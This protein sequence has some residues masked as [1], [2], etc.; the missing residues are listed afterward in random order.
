M[1]TSKKLSSDAKAFVPSSQLKASA[2][3]WTP[4]SA[5]TSS[6]ATTGNGTDSAATAPAV[7][8]SSNNVPGKNTTNNPNSNSSEV[9][10]DPPSVAPSVTNV[11]GKNASSAIRKAPTDEQKAIIEG[12][13]KVPTGTGEPMPGQRP[14][15]HNH[16]LRRHPQHPHQQHNDKGVH[17]TQH[18]KHD[19]DSWARGKKPMQPKN[20]NDDGWQRGKLVPLDLIKPGEGDLDANKNVKRILAEHILSLR[21]SFLDPPATWDKRD[22]QEGSGG[23]GCGA[24]IACRWISDSRIE[25]IRAITNQQRLGG[26]VSSHRKVKKENDTAPPLEE[27]KPL[28]INEDTRWKATVFKKEKD[29]EDTDD[30]VLKKALLILNKLSITKF[31]KLSDAFLETGIGRNENCL[32][33]AIGL[34]VKK[35]QDEPH[36]SAMYASL[37]LKLART[38]MDF[39]ESG[40][41]KKFK[42]MLLAECQK[43]FETDTNTKIEKATEGVED[44]EER[45]LKADLVKKHYLGH[46]RFIGE[47][48]KGDL[49]TIKIMLMVL[50]Q[51]LEGNMNDGGMDEDK[52]ECF[53]KLMTVIGLILEQQSAALRNIGK[54]DASEKL[55]ECWEKVEALAG[56]K[57]N[58]AT[59]SN[60][61]KF[62]L[63]DLL[64]MKENGWASRRKEESAKT[65]EEIHKD[66]AKEVRRMSSS[67]SRSAS[68]N[69][70]RA[71]SVKPAVDSDGFVEVLGSGRGFNRPKSVGNLRTELQDNQFENKT[72]PSSGSKHRHVSSDQET[73]DE[74]KR[75]VSK[76]ST[77]VPESRKVSEYLE[78]SMCANKAVRC[79]KE[80]FVSGDA[81]ETVLTI[82]ELIGAGTDG[83]IKRAAKVIESTVLMV[84]EMKAEEV[85]KYQE[86]ITRCYNEKKIE[87]ASF[88]EAL[89]YPFESLQDIAIDAPLANI[90]LA[91]IVASF[92]K[93]GAISFDYLWKASPDSFRTEGGAAKFGVN[94]LKSI[95]GDALKAKSNLDVIEQLMTDDDKAQY[96]SAIEM[97]SS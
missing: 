36:F 32:A 96:A 40:K 53:A 37:C 2:A 69:S 29:N 47:L 49:I 51:L 58:D 76:T 8:S 1:T 10:T 43:E 28:E 17:K 54:T 94:V 38:P 67:V 20:H 24:P 22:E 89:Y 15:G 11:W 80:Y 91:S 83:S 73:T 4:K 35:A 33:G 27:C 18:N 71:Q 87:Q 56:K 64:E 84:L 72:K 60:R 88:A 39:E 23:G 42:K 93:C 16:R 19:G 95:G 41:N 55:S 30:V 48:Y 14:T 50:P 85:K 3:V 34:I 61:I 65:I 46:M 66:A 74:P 77:T 31:E 75:V 44:A 92:I 26:D 97:T 57:N 62:M 63:Q 52:I 9:A 25:D 78:P 70:L 13:S 21:L 68:S 12:S 90:H 81:N 86:M 82:E 59:I 5:V 7:N 79:F 6:F 45:Q